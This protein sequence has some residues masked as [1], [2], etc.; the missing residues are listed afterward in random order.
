MWCQKA[1]CRVVVAV[2][3]SVVVNGATQWWPRDQLHLALNLGH[4]LQAH[5]QNAEPLEN[6]ILEV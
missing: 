3:D 4:L 5:P 1:C 6:Q 2:G